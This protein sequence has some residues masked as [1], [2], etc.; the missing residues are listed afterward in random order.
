MP[1]TRVL[2]FR[3]KRGEDA[4]TSSGLYIRGGQGEIVSQ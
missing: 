1:S 3:R 2:D 4:T